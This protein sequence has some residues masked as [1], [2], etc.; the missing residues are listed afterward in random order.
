VKTTANGSVGLG[1]SGILG[2]EDEYL[3][4]G[5][6]MRREWVS[7]SPFGLLARLTCVIQSEGP[8]AVNL[9][10]ETHI[11]I[12]HGRSIGNIWHCGKSWYYT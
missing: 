7:I 9:A 1:E 2:M 12:E 8:T 3:D 4:E 11:I 10:D 5:S 6:M